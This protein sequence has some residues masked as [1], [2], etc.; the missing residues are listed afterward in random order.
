MKFSKGCPTLSVFQDLSFSCFMSS[1]L[2]TFDVV[3]NKEFYC[4]RPLIEC[5]RVYSLSRCPRLFVIVHSLHAQ[6]QT[7]IPVDIILFSKI[8]A[9]FNEVSKFLVGY[10]AEVTGHH[11]A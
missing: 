11:V 4:A 6:F 3:F 7:Q 9:F 5:A 2:E 8:K 10:D 1:R